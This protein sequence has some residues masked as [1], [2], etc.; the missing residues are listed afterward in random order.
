MEDNMLNSY[1]ASKYP[2][3]IIFPL[4]TLISLRIW[5][6]PQFCVCRGNLS[7]ERPIA[8]RIVL[9]NYLESFRPSHLFK[10]HVGHPFLQPHVR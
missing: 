2:D 4:V 6:L 5:N 7:R 3:V 8:G 9:A 10:Q 1:N